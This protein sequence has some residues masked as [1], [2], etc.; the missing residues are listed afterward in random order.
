M[1]KNQY[2]LN[3]GDLRERISILRRSITVRSGITTETWEV[4]CTVWAKAEP[5][6]GRAYFQAAAVNRENSI[7]FTIRYRADVTAEM[8]V[9]WRGVEYGIESVVNPG[10]RNVALEILTRSEASTE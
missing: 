1:P 4:L 2:D 5:L 6:S 9:G 10:G 8:T 3:A 7:R